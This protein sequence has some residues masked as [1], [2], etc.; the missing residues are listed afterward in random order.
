[1]KNSGLLPAVVL[2]FVVCASLNAQEDVEDIEKSEENISKIELKIDLPFFDFPYQ[3]DVMKAMGYNFFQTYSAFSME[4]SLKLTTGVYSAMHYGLKKMYDNLSFEPFWNNAIYYGT[5][6]AGI[7]AFGYFLPFGYPWMK[8]EYVHS[9]LNLN[10][11]HG[12]NGTYR[13]ID[14]S[15]LIG[16]TDDELG[17]FKRNTPYDFI[18]MNSAGNEAYNIF[19]DTLIRNYFYYDPDDLSWISA[20]VATFVNFGAN[21]SPI[22]VFDGKNSH[23]IIMFDYDVETILEEWYKNDKGQETRYLT[24]FDMLNWG[25]ELFHPDEPYAARGLH[26]SGDGSIA[27]YITFKQ[28]TDD[29]MKY[30]VKHSYLSYLNFVSPLL[31]GVRSFPLGNSGLEANFALRHYLTSFGTDITATVFLKKKPFNMA[32]TYHSYQNYENYFPAIE[33]ELVD[34]PLHI[35]KLGMYISPRVLIGMQP[36]GQ[37]FKTGSAEFLGLFGLR[38]DFMAGKNIFPFVDFSVKTS[39]W[40]AGNEYL[41]A[42]ASITLGVSLRF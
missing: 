17:Y 33:A 1:V 32:F 26:P 12:F 3:S 27:R 23:G 8:Q 24:G 16:V 21:A 22:I 20:L 39:G 7:L 5:T 15:A 31:Y 6:T 36:K 30:L 13:I 35:G 34:Y 38:V 9:I 29:E 4:Q 28:F 40:V 11:I 37:E 2:C 18:R 14:R 10:E 42:N 25:Y 41:G 19:S